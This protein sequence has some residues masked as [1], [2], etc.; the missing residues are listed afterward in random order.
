MYH[1]NVHL[2][3][4]GKNKIHIQCPWMVTCYK[5]VCDTGRICMVSRA[6]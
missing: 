6:M 3:S 1:D 4:V 5:P 2:T